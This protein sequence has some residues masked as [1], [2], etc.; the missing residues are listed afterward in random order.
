[1]GGGHGVGDAGLLEQVHL[2]E[3]LQNKKK[4]VSSAELR[5]EGHSQKRESS[6]KVQV[7][8]RLSHGHRTGRRTKFRAS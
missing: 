3:D 6:V 1:M 7:K 2:N 4:P 8:E 5:R